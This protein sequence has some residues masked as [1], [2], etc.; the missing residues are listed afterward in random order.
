MQWHKQY[1]LFGECDKCDKCGVNLLP[2]CP[3]E[4]KGSDDYVVTWRRFVLGQTMSVAGKPQK[5]LN[6][7]HNAI[8]VD[9]LNAYLKPK[10]Q[11]FVHHNFVANWRDM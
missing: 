1:C 4:T 5:K 7:I 11:Y 10:L 3:K 9:E 6:L 2:L 8:P